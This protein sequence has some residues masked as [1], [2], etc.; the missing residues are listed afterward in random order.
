MCALKNYWYENLIKKKEMDLSWLYL[1]RNSVQMA[2][3]LRAT[4][5]LLFRPTLPARSGRS[6]LLIDERSLT[7]NAYRDRTKPCAKNTEWSSTTSKVS[8]NSLKS[9]LSRR[10]GFPRQKGQKRPRRR[11][12]NVAQGQTKNYKAVSL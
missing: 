11:R 6:T 10:T 12:Q 4:W 1:K 8:L 7:C 3:M 2:A 9:P 5:A